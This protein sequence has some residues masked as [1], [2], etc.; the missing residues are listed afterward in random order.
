MTLYVKSAYNPLLSV[1]IC[2]S[3]SVIIC[4]IIVQLPLIPSPVY[5]DYS[6]PWLGVFARARRIT[7]RTHRAVL[8]AQIY[9]P[10]PWDLYDRRK[11]KEHTHWFKKIYRKRYFPEI[12]CHYHKCDFNDKMLWA[13]FFKPTSALKFSITFSN[14]ASLR[15]ASYVFFVARQWTRIIR[16]CVFLKAVLCQIESCW[17]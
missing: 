5:Q 15:I 2:V 3:Q 17:L 6:A 4:A 7:S 1:L 12:R 14:C 11:F 13:M 9:S 16:Q 10:G 8:R